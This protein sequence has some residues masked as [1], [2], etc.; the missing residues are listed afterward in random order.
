MSY[1]H[2]KAWRKKCNSK[3]QK[4]KSRYYKQFEKQAYNSRQEYTI[5]QINMIVDKKY[6]DREIALRIGR[7]V[8][9]IQ[10]KRGR[11]NN[12]ILETKEILYNI[13]VI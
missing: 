4:Q 5:K 12:K 3:W 10:I 8:K 9:A 11:V 2:N 1:E 13:G 6:P 7:S